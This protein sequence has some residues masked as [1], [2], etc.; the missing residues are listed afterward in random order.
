[1]LFRA[2]KT[3]KPQLTREE[4]LAARPALNPLVK[5]E[6]ADDGAV[7]LHVPRR[8]NALVRTVCRVFRLPPYRRVALD[9]L[10]SFV[11]QLCDGRR[12]VSEVVEKF[13]E[14]FRLSRRDAEVSVVTFLRLLA[15]R[16][17]VGLVIEGEAKGRGRR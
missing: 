17:I 13:A 10:G 1:M 8:D 7:I 15:R 11:I 9:E 16:A 3:G 2:R 4:S 14:Q 5:I 6:K 12:P